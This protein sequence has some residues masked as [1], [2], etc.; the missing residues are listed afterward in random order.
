LRRIWAF[1]AWLALILLTAYLLMIC[2]A[3][4]T[5]RFDDDKGMVVH[6]DPNP[7]YGV[8][9]D[10]Y[11]PS[12]IN[13]PTVRIRFYADDTVHGFNLRVESA[14]KRLDR[15]G[16]TITRVRP[17]YRTNDGVFGGSVEIYTR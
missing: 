3:C 6:K 5:I 16:Y 1:I 9:V 10:E 4:T 14:K 12:S 15:L 13:P 17:I 7:F 8:S 2:N 11:P